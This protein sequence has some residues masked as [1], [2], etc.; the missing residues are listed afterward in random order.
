MKCATQAPSAEVPDEP[1]TQQRPFLCRRGGVEVGALGMVGAA[2]RVE[3][4]GEAPDGSEA[5]L[6][7]CDMTGPDTRDLQL[8]LA[9]EDYVFAGVGA[10][11]IHDYPTAQRFA[12]SLINRR[13]FAQRFPLAHRQLSIPPKAR[14]DRF[15]EPA[16]WVPVMAEGTLCEHG[17][18]YVTHTEPTRGTAHGTQAISLDL[19]RGATEGMVVHELAHLV[20]A[21]ECPRHRHDHGIEFI[22]HMLQLVG[23]AHG[24]SAA[25][26]LRA[27]HR[28]QGTLTQES[29]L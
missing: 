6:G 9:E 29:R 25:A 15:P 23:W 14:Y 28:D 18:R 4:F 5:T 3:Q 27:A 17:V 22:E 2:A 21:I 8:Y 26:E 16:A 13:E 12:D 24:R 10:A 1:V 11:A 20:T 19:R 7:R